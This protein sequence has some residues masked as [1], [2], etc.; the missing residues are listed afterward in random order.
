MA[1]ID[2]CRSTPPPGLPGI[3]GG[4]PGDGGYNSGHGRR[5]GPQ[6][7]LS[8]AWIAAGEL[9]KHPNLSPTHAHDSADSAKATDP[10]REPNSNSGS[11]QHSFE[12]HAWHAVS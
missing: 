10:Q 6:D 3:P 2:A 8:N 7:G 4:D 5:H 11:G 9:F 1:L 12:T